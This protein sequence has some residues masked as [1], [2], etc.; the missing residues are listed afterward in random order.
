[1][2]CTS[3]PIEFSN[4]INAVRCGQTYLICLDT[5]ASVAFVTAE[6]F[7]TM[8]AR[9]HAMEEKTQ[10]LQRDSDWH[11]SLRSYLWGTLIFRCD[12]EVIDGAVWLIPE[13]PENKDSADLLVLVREYSTGN[14]IEPTLSSG[15]EHLA[16]AYGKFQD[17]FHLVKL[18]PGSRIQFRVK[19]RTFIP[20]RGLERINPF[21]VEQYTEEE[22]IQSELFLRDDDSTLQY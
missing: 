18:S 6:S 1:M 21:H 3:G 9:G 4:G 7:K 13:K 2:R 8:L 19:E 17:R 5:N 15:A 16:S 12:F 22:R 20:P 11:G 10:I 14:N